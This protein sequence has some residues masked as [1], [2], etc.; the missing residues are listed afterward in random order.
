MPAIA[1]ARLKRH[2]D[3][4]VMERSLELSLEKLFGLES[5]LTKASP[6]V[7]PSKVDEPGGAK[8][9][10]TTQSAELAH[11]A[12]QHLQ[13]AKASYGDDWAIFGQQMKKL[14]HVLKDLNDQANAQALDP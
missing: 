6:L 1:H 14:E 12:W 11:R 5:A 3:Q 4:I 8:S 9:N 2:G 10:S 13:H 7:S